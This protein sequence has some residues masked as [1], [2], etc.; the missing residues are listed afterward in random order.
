MTDPERHPHELEPD[1]LEI[2]EDDE[3]EHDDGLVSHYTPGEDIAIVF[4]D[5]AMSHWAWLWGLFDKSKLGVRVLVAG[6]EDWHASKFSTVNGSRAVPM[7]KL[8]LSID[9]ETHYRKKDKHE[10]I[11]T[12][13]DEVRSTWKEQLALM[14]VCVALSAVVWVGVL[15][16]RD[17]D[18]ALYLG[19]EH[20]LL[21]GL[22][23]CSFYGWRIRGPISYVKFVTQMR[24]PFALT[25]GRL[26]EAIKRRNENMGW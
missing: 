1:E 11:M 21:L 15:P 20:G 18:F 10:C 14:I 5:E 23:L 2:S 7:K 25:P 9:P 24:A 16:I 4:S 26:N 19:L 12:K 3:V 13:A 22:W 17:K 8:S 6:E